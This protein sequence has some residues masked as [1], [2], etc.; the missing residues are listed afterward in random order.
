MHFLY[1]REQ[2]TIAIQLSEILESSF[3]SFP[4]TRKEYL[5]LLLKQLWLKCKLQY[6]QDLKT[7]HCLINLNLHIY[8]KFEGEMVS[9]VENKK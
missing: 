9:E 3:K 5:F 8:I 7:G 6:L 2:P 4:L 1:F